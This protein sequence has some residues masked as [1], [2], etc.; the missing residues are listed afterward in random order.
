MLCKTHT[1]GSSIPVGKCLRKTNIL[2]LRIYR[3][4]WILVRPWQVFRCLQRASPQAYVLS[5]PRFLRGLS[6]RTY[7]TWTKNENEFKHQR[8]TSILWMLFMLQCRK[9]F[10]YFREI[11]G[12]LC[13]YVLM[14][15]VERERQRQRESII[16]YKI[17]LSVE[18]HEVLHHLNKLVFSRMEVVGFSCL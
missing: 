18:L 7:Q 8:P 15:M 2:W 13:S 9:K 3:N 6:C 12:I 11:L 5:H 4:N 17:D 16:I 14:C 1:D 10:S